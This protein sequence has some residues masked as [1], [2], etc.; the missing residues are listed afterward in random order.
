MP[1]VSK[2]IRHI[3]PQVVGVRVTEVQTDSVGREWR[4]AYLATDEATA[5]TTMN[6]RDLT[7]QI[8]DQEER[9]MIDFIKAGGDPDDFVNTDISVLGKRRRLVKRFSHA[10]L[11]HRRQ[12]L[13][14]LAPWIGALTTQQIRDAFDGTPNPLSVPDAN[15]IRLRAIELR[16]NL[17]TAMDSDDTAI[18]EDVG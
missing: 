13:C 5:T 18:N 4:Y 12:L 6:A 17:C 7:E 9:E 16:D 15:G 11:T 14:N 8:K 3:R 10:S 2:E 1:I